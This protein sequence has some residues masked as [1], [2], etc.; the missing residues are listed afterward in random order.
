MAIDNPYCLD[1]T[2]TTGI[3]SSLGRSIQAENGLII[4]DII[5][6]DAAINPGNSGGPLLNAQGQ[7]IGINSQIATGGTGNGNVGIGFAVP[8]NTAKSAIPQLEKS[9]RV[10]H[11][12]LGVTTAVVT[13][14]DAKSLNLPTSKGALVQEL[15][16]GRPAD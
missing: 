9:G 11:A 15:T 4:D 1:R 16:D 8:I 12:F 3:I 7:V 10:A 5:Q 2:L 6:T 14:D 13:N